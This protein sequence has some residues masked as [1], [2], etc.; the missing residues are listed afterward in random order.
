MIYALISVIIALCVAIA[1]LSLDSRRTRLRHERHVA[2]LQYA[3]VQLTADNDDQLRQIRLS[4]DLRQKL[5]NARHAL[6]RDLMEVQ[7][8]MVE[9]LSRHNLLD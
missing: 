3:I 4:D 5:I 9:T 8:D 7:H 2:E 6:D 1:A